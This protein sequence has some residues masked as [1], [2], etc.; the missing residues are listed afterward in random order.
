MDLLAV[1]E[2]LE[3]RVRYGPLNN[4]SAATVA[5]T[6]R[7]PG[8]DADLA[9]GFLFGEG[10]F[11]DATELLG[12]HDSH[13][14]NVIRVDLASDVHVDLERLKRNVYISS[15][16]GVC[17]KTSLDA[18]ETVCEPVTASL[19]ISPAII[20]SLPDKL[21]QAQATFARTGGLHAAG[22]FDG[23]GQLLNLREDVG[24]HNAVDKLFGAEVRAGRTRLSDRVLVVSG[25]ASF[26]LIQKAAMIGVTVFVAVGAPSS[27]AVQ[28]AERVGM[29]LLGFV[30][31]GRFNQYSGP[32][33]VDAE[34]H[35]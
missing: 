7:T 6:M 8:H 15:S 29:T 4:R 9:T 25:R 14:A 22:L 26:E 10:L 30:R 1:E 13:T 20:H 19:P 28:L 5:I 17:G 2:P 34:C 24:R 18:V 31:D 3:I 27:L 32:S 35:S 12:I 23:M 21:R 11:H 16:C 33:L